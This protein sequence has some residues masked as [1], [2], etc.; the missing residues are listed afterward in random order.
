MRLPQQALDLLQSLSAAASD[1][2]AP[3]ERFRHELDFCLRMTEAH[4][5]Q[6]AV[7]T[8]LL[9][10]SVALV[11]SGLESGQGAAEVVAAAEA[12]LAPLGAAAKQY[13]LFCIGHA[14]IDMNWMWTW[15][16]TVS[17]CYD[18]FSTMDQLM[19]EFP[20]F[21]FSQSQVSVYRAMQHYAPEL[22]ERIRARIAEGRWD[23]TASN[24][25]EG[26]KN[27]ACGESLC[28]H[29]LYSK[30]WLRE[31]LG[32][33]YDAVKIDWSCDTFG[34]AW[35]VPTILARGGV[36]RYYLH[37]SGS[38]RWA[39]VAGGEASRL[40]WF[41]G[42]DGS[43]VL[44]FDDGPHGY[45]GQIGP[46]IVNDLWNWERLTGLKQMLWVYGVGDHGGG[47]TRRHLR[48]ALDMQTWPLWPQL[49]LTTTDD[50]FSTVEAQL[51]EGQ[52][53]VIS[54]ELNFNLE[55]C[56]VSES[57]I[58]FANRQGENALLDSEPIALL[59]HH[60]CGME[61][62][63]TALNECW[64]RAMFLQFHDILPGSGVRETYEHAQGL[65][66]ET[67]AE[68]GMIKARSLRALA[69]K[70]DTSA[71]AP[72]RPDGD[73][74]LGAGAGNGAYWTGLSTLGA[75][76]SAGDPFVIFNPAP[77]VRDELVRVKIWDRSLP[78]RQAA[79]MPEPEC[80][81]VV[82]D[83][84]GRVLPGQIVDEG[85]Y[86]GHTF[87]EV[88]FPVAAL[89][90]LGYRAYTVEIGEAPQ[91]RGACYARET[92]RPIYGLEY[93]GQELANPVV[94]GNEY[95]EMTVDARAGGIVSLVDKPSGLELVEEGSV[96]GALL[97]QQEAPHVMTAWLF[98]QILEEVEP[99][100]MGSKLRFAARG[101]HLAAVEL[102]ARYGE[103]TYRLTISLAAGK[104]QV[105]FDL[106]VNWIERGDPSTGVPTLRAAFPLAIESGRA[107]C[108][109]PCGI[110][111]RP[112]DG[113]EVP[114]LNWVDLTGRAAWLPEQALGATL[115][116]DC[117][118]GHRL[119]ENTI[120]VTLLRSTYDPDPIPEYG[121]SRIRYALVPHVG[122]FDA[123]AA[124]QA[125]Y[126]FNHP[127]LPVNT[128][129]HA[130]ELPP[131][132]EHLAFLTPHVMLSGLKR[133]E[134]SE[135]VV[136]RLYEFGGQESEA[137][138]R[139]SAALVAPDSPAV[140]TDLIEQPLASSTARMEG[141]VLK[142]TIP[143]YGIA[144]VK[145]G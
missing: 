16:E 101:P 106:D 19:V 4:P 69:G 60:L 135:A 131:E 113:E 40:F 73:D 114:A 138:V 70:V 77:F 48:A 5:E 133:A 91:A 64:E 124:V 88:A 93:M 72:R 33:P 17:V 24:W 53:P 118:Y 120:Q 143:A 3:L 119:S 82:R 145:V 103:S 65:F 99:L 110:L 45:N 62:P 10:Q 44:A 49:K 21:H 121:R 108:E 67:L 74:G 46:H 142:V 94:L 20:Q 105:D 76:A 79:R 23:V 6:A 42:P 129:V 115:V 86:W 9:E 22:F 134:D 130:G 30:R 125:G 38:E 137:Q 89:P 58:K 37:R 12:L 1:A 78:L 26:D 71:L 92:G 41:Q 47:P 109:I 14:H 36:T 54:G 61:Y 13:T 128:T 100:A 83:S 90:G 15:P 126:A 8:P 57:R 31:N 81:F 84:V 95:L 29:L 25:V 51:E 2:H 127:C 96:L 55:G 35:T 117:K 139:L 132:A 50:F 97:R 63:L 112:A 140:E 18:T 7:W 80:G 123:A 66:Q 122:E 32:L 34:H 111:E 116:N 136:V 56:Y 104:R 75:G 102:T 98:A 59:A 141:D 68:T 39:Q 107:R 27:M 43:R 52:I 85:T 28:R 87:H 144:T 11:A